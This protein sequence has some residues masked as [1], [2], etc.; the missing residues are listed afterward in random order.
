VFCNLALGRQDEAR[1]HIEARGLSPALRRLS[2]AE[3]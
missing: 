1:G 3:D 2:A